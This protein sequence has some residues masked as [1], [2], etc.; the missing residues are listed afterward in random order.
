MIVIKKLIS[1]AML[2]VCALAAQCAFAVESRI[3][4]HVPFSFLVAGRTMPAGEYEVE[5]NDNDVVYVRGGHGAVMV[6]SLPK[7][8]SRDEKPALVFAR[9]GGNVYLIGV[10]TADS[11]RSLSV[12]KA[13]L[14]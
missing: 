5:T 9:R 2:A 11:E 1:L 8:F 10:K 13:D 3:T 4:L 7:S 12:A 14:R 6:T